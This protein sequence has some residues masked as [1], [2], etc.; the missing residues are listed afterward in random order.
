MHE[1]V[2]R[3]ILAGGLSF[4]DASL[5]SNVE[6]ASHAKIADLCQASI[7]FQMLQ[8]VDPST[9]PYKVA[10]GWTIK[11]PLPNILTA[12]RSNEGRL[13]SSP[14]TDCA[15]SHVFAH[16]EAAHVGGVPQTASLRH[17]P[18]HEWL[19]YDSHAL[20]YEDELADLSLL[21]LLLGKQCPRL[22]LAALDHNEAHPDANT[23]TPASPNADGTEESPIFTSIKATD[24]ELALRDA[25]SNGYLSIVEKILDLGADIRS[26]RSNIPAAGLLTQKRGY[27]MLQLLLSRGLAINATTGNSACV[28]EILVASTSD[29]LSSVRWV[30]GSGADVNIKPSGGYGSILEAAISTTANFNN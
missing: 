16:M 23:V 13:L 2:R 14:L 9:A 26:L 5:R 29:T 24:V 18:W 1:S 4:L 11:E 8:G 27:D 12:T 28:L 19:R 21:Q 20:N 17:F 7:R 6:A 15:C 25:V 30:L 10:P 22:A 3:Q